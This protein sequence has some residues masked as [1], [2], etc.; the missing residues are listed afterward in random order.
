MVYHNAV[1]VEHNGQGFMNSDGDLDNILSFVVKRIEG[2]AK[3][4]GKPLSDEEALLLNDL[5]TAPLF[6]QTVTGDP[7]LPPPMPIPRD[8]AYERLIALAREALRYD[9]RRD[10]ASDREWRYAATVCK[11][12]GHPMLWLLHWAGIK[13]Q[14]AWW[15]R[16]LLIMSAILLTFCFLAFM[17]L[18]IVETWTRLSWITAC[19]GYFVLALLLYFS[20]RYVE[21]WQLRREIQ[22]YRRVTVISR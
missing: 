7:E 11:L 18:G 22:K 2:E 14:K 12:H 19:L 17:L 21:E 8:L 9:V 6:P 20:C 15:D 5:P 4:L 16:A 10:S 13:E 3:R 1:F